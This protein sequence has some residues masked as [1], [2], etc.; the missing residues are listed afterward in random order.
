MNDK[1]ATCD[2]VFAKKSFFEKRFARDVHFFNENLFFFFSSDLLSL[3]GGKGGR[4]LGAL[5]KIIPNICERDRNIVIDSFDLMNTVSRST[6]SPSRSTWAPSRSSDA[7]AAELH[8]FR[9]RHSKGNAARSAPGA[10][11]SAR[12]RTRDALRDKSTFKTQQR[13]FS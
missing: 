7:C 4:A 9:Y 13:G 10:G 11:A 3:D 5:C 8:L 12:R 1:F 2:F 6:W